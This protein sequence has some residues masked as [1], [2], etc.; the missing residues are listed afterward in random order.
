MSMPNVELDK[1][2][3]KIV[4]HVK[5]SKIRDITIQMLHVYNSLKMIL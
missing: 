2:R 5:L 3:I 4:K 1:N